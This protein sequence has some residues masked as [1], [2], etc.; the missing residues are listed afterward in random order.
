MTDMI[1]PV[2]SAAATVLVFVTVPI[3][4]LMVKLLAE[5][6]HTLEEGLKDSILYSVTQTAYMV[7]YS[8]VPIDLLMTDLKTMSGKLA[9]V[10]DDLMGQ[11][12]DIYRK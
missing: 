2:L 8:N 4:V 9:N 10:P 12:L 3:L 5:R 7:K 1:M 6:V 11:I